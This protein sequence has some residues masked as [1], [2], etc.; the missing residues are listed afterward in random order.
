MTRRIREKHAAYRALHGTEPPANLMP[1]PTEEQI[2]MFAA[3][4]YCNSGD[5]K[6]LLTATRKTAG[7]QPENMK[8]WG[9]ELS[10]VKH[11][12]FQ[13]LNGLAYLHNHKVCHRDLKPDNLMLHSG[14][15]GSPMALKIG[16]LGL[17]REL[18]ASVGDVT[19]TVCT[20][21]YRPLEVILGKI[22]FEPRSIA[23]EQAGD[24]AGYGAHYGLGC[25]LWSAGCIMA[26][27]V[28]GAPLFKGTQE[29]EVVMRITRVLGTPTHD[30][31]TNCDKLEH[32]PFKDRD[33]S[34][35]FSEKEKRQNLNSVLLGK[36]D[37]DG[38]DL[39]S[40]MLDYNPHTRVTAAEA[41]SH[42]WFTDVIYNR[43]DGIGVVNW[44]TESMKYRLGKMTFSEM[45][46]IDP[47]VLVSSKLAHVITQEG[48]QGR[49]VERIDEAF[50]K[51]GGFKDG[52]HCALWTNI[53]QETTGENIRSGASPIAPR[54]RPDGQYE[55]VLHGHTH[56]PI[57]CVTTTDEEYASSASRASP[58]SGSTADS[59]L[60]KTERTSSVREPSGD[61]LLVSAIL[62]RDMAASAISMR[63]MDPAKSYD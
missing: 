19:P 7:E 57:S 1:S 5:L 46:K 37:W 63:P 28:R 50:H 58:L 14:G 31:W 39:L 8:N 43:L 56:S 41:L 48:Y 26:E 53:V 3:Y 61:N 15:A 52:P 11:F 2:Y 27:M 51:I 62:R 49:L 45:E 6:K 35:Y 16:D 32:Y 25:D 47:G 24:H 59:S 42:Q 55:I 22:R 10:E 38:L 34:H 12:T 29:F 33:G 4:E 60:D 21:Y 54:T 40:R 44:Y 17:C 13:L 9:L 30:D 36:L 20:I 18:R 23:Q